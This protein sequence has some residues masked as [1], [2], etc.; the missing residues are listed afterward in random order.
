MNNIVFRVHPTVNFARFGTS[1]EYI[2][3]PETSAGLPQKGSKV[4]GGLPI[5]KGTDNTPISSKDLRDEDGNLKKQAARFRIYAYEKQSEATYPDN[6]GLKDS[7][8][9]D[10]EVTIGTKL[11]DGRTVTDLLWSSHLANKKAAVYNVVNNKGIKAYADGQVPQMRNPEVHGKIDDPSRLNVLMIDAGPRAISASSNETA[12]FNRCS[13]ASCVRDQAQIESLPDYPIRFPED[14]NDELYEPNGPLNT[15]GDMLTDDQGRLLVLSSSGNSVGQYDEYGVPIQMTGDLNNVGWFDS[16]ADGPV[17]VTLVF[18]DGSTEAAFG[19][20]VVCGDPAYAPQIRNVVSVWDDVYDMFVRDLSLQDNLYSKKNNALEGTY[21]E[22]YK[23]NFAEDIKPIFIACDLQ[24]WTAN[25]PPMALH[26]HSA[27]VNITEQN[28]PNE[29][30]MAALNFIR[31]PNKDETNIG[32]PLMPLS[33]GAAGTSFLTVTKTQYFMLEQWS[34]GHFTKGDDSKLSAGELIDMASMAN[35]LGGRYVPGI[36]VSYTIMDRDIYIQDWKESGSGPFRIKHDLATLAY[37]GLNSDTPYLSS[38]WIPLHDMTD[39]L[40]PG[41]ISKFMATPW[42][43]DYN[44]CSIHATAINTDGTNKSNGAE[45][46]LYWSWPAQ[47]PDAVYVAEEVFNNVL[48]KQQWS[49]RGPGTYAINP[50]AA[51]TFQD[52]LQSV[53]DWHKI[54][55]IIQGTNVD[56]DSQDF[57][58]EL[59]LEVQSQLSRPGDATDPVPAWPFNANSPKAKRKCSHK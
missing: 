50:A 29:T 54:G 30:I 46:T 37:R 24:R 7:K 42:Q 17:N 10:I 55:F 25:L 8:G 12:S 5:K 40:Q 35:C 53:S 4:T 27:V 6:N 14:Y 34:K 1:D 57:S 23:P 32:A 9:V 45:S 2:L 3:S 36:E 47:R 49:I 41:D 52:P 33:L 58:P 13:T 51:A 21:K 22:S 48:P 59:Y 44:S 43:T 16:A 56:I 18:D 19:A 20:W 39:G 38:G 31:N 26:A 15:L 28:D 11:P